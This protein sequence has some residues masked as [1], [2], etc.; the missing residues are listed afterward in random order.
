MNAWKSQGMRDGYKERGL[1][2]RVG[3]LTLR[4]PEIRDG[5]FSIDYSLSKKR[6]SI[7]C[8]LDGDGRKWPFD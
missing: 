5:I 8:Y 7:N 6:K 1:T 3:T 4:V 2:T